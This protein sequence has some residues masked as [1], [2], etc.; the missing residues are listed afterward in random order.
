MTDAEIGEAITIA[1]QLDAIAG[2]QDDQA[3][4]NTNTGDLLR[5]AA[6]WMRKLIEAAVDLDTPPVI[7]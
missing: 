7:P 2:W 3:Q 4:C 1:A 6:K 5:S